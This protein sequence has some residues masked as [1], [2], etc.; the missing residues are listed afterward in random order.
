MPTLEQQS[1][2][3]LTIERITFSSSP[4]VSCKAED[5]YNNEDGQDYVGGNHGDQRRQA[6]KIAAITAC[7]AEG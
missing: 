7:E 2:W 1:E 5:R 6:Y 3:A 4:L